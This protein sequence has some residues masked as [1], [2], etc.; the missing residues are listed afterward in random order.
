[1]VDVV[2]GDIA[3]LVL[4]FGQG[5]CVHEITNVAH[6][7]MLE[8][9]ALY[10]DSPFLPDLCEARRS[11]VEGVLSSKFSGMRECLVDFDSYGVD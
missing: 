4:R 5:R 7:A 2:P 9:D 8:F 3:L 6:R 1:M 11:Y 10:T